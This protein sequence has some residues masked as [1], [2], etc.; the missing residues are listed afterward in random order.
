VLHA[1]VVAGDG[2]NAFN[3][4]DSYLAAPRDAG[5]DAVAVG[6]HDNLSLVSSGSWRAD[7]GHTSDSFCP[8]D[9]YCE[10]A[11]APPARVLDIDVLDVVYVLD[12]GGVAEVPPD[13]ALEFDLIDVGGV[14][15][16]PLPEALPALLAALGALGLFAGR[17]RSSAAHRPA[18]G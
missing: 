11:A 17:R 9:L 2:L 12:A 18:I 13:L 1:A 14:A 6:N 16:V 7:G 5:N 3:A 4:L 15:T 8:V 10:A